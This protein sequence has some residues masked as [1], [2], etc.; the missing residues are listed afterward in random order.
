MSHW[1]KPWLTF[2]PL[3]HNRVL[4][5]DWAQVGHGVR[6]CVMLVHQVVYEEAT[7]PAQQ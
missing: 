7:Y 2:V 5:L 4:S 1:E 3:G 6:G